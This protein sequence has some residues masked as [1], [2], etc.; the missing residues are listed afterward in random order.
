[1]VENNRFGISTFDK[2]PLTKTAPKRKV[3]VVL[4]SLN[5]SPTR[6]STHFDRLQTT[7]NT[8]GTARANQLKP[9]KQSAEPSKITDSLTLTPSHEQTTPCKCPSCQ[10]S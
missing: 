9:V 6:V 4:T 8:Q 1:M 7:Q 10:K 3:L 5:V 2:K